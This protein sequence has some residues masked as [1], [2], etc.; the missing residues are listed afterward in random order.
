MIT[1]ILSGGSGSRLWPVSRESYPK[2]FCEFFD[3]SFLQNT[4]ERLRPFGLPYIVTLETMG[5]LTQNAL[6]QAGVSGDRLLLEPLPKNTAAAVALA[7]HHAQQQ[8]LDDEVLGVFPADHLITDV[9]LFRRAVLLAE[10]LAKNN[11]VVTLGIHPRYAATGYG[12]LEVDSSAKENSRGELP[13]YPVKRF[14]EKPSQEKAEEFLRLKN[15]YWNAGI[16]IFKVSHMAKLFEI[17]MPELWKKIT[18]IKADLSNIKYVYANL[19]SQSIDYGIME[20]LRDGVLCIPGDF[21]WSDVGSWDELARLQEEKLQIAS[22]ANVFSFNAT[23]NFVYSNQNKVVGLSGVDDLIVVDTPDA[24]LV[25]KRGESQDV[26][27]LVEMMREARL[28]Q[29]DE[30]SFE[31]RPWGRFEVLSDRVD[32]KVKRLIVEPGRQ[33]SYQ[34]H[35]KRDEHWTFVSGMGEVILNDKVLSFKSGEQVYIPRGSKHRLRNLGHAPLV[36][37]EVQTGEYFGEDDIKRFQDDFNRV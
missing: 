9:E 3:Q 18:S 37:I 10:S 36:I 23:D 13:A 19:I 8:K 2:Q 11:Q 7:V 1:V 12:Y 30:H 26:K 17:H 35:E 5:I 6:S 33:L 4:I 21:G 31:I 24:L 22:N 16:F 25:T 34:Q 27:K 14:C 28:P 20:K 29:A 32:H 15:H